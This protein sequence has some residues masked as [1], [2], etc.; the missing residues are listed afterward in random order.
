MAYVYQHIRLDNDSVFYIGI[1][2]DTQG[3]YSR[4][5]R[6][7]YRSEYWERIVKKA[8]YRI[9][10]VKDGITWEEAKEIEREMIR[11]IGRDKL[12]NLTDGG[13]G[14]LG[15]V[16]DDETR[17]TWSDQRKGAP[18]SFTGRKHSE[19]TK[20][21][22]SER[23]KGNTIWKGRH[24]SDETKKKLSQAKKGQPSPMRK[25]VMCIETGVV[26]DS[27]EEAARIL[28]LPKN[29]VN[30]AA[31]GVRKHTGGFHFKFI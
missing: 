26:Y 6:K 27:C 19:E 29:G 16:P 13:D 18:S 24:Q 1:G 2:S 4:A 21:K 30:R 25:K 15:W 8:G 5:K 7:S 14:V 12:C 10:I 23:M 11:K 9:E 28:G 3:Y 31:S 17:R 22:L 20:K